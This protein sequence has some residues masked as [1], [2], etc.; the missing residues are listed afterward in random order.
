MRP[1]ERFLAALAGAPV[2]RVPIFDWV[3]NPAIY[4]D[5]L[6]VVPGGFD[7]A[8]AARLSAALGLDACW[9]PDGGF[10]GLPQARYRW[11]DAARYVDEWGVTW[12][13]GEGS[14]PLA[15]PVAH[16]VRL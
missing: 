10:L 14:R 8:L 5:A 3:N 16:A 4:A 9:A 13:V 11:L 12:Q 6:G 7:G 1:R 15:F 2:D